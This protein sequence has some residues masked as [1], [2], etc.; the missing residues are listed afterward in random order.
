MA[1]PLGGDRGAGGVRLLVVPAGQV[2]NSKAGPP[3]EGRWR[4]RVQD[5]GLILG[6][7]V[8]TNGATSPPGLS[9]VWG[10]VCEG[11]RGRRRSLS[12]ARPGRAG[13][14]GQQNCSGAV[15]LA[16]IPL[17]AWLG[18]LAVTRV[19]RDESRRWM[20]VSASGCA[21]ASH[22][23]VVVEG[24]CPPSDG[25]RLEARWS[26]ALRGYAEVPGGYG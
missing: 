21:P 7:G 6:R 5:L 26:P 12:L 9:G 1:R 11:D 19:L 14:V 17:C 20:R 15:R 4:V 13:G 22:G 23:P 18:W 16:A 25:G 3:R 2:D 10:V 24:C 8:L